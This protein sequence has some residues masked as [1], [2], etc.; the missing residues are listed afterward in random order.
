MLFVRRFR[1]V[2]AALAA[3]AM[4]VVWMTTLQIR[5]DEGS[6]GSEV[7]RVK[8]TQLFKAAD[9]IYF[10]SA[11]T[12]IEMTP[13]QVVALNDAIRSATD[14]GDGHMERAGAGYFIV[15]DDKGHEQDVVFKRDPSDADAI[16]VAPFGHRFTLPR[17][18]SLVVTLLDAVEGGASASTSS[19]KPPLSEPAKSD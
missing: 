1:W 18:R 5:H 19:A 12:R 2:L 7:D 15:V 17:M 16:I 3:V 4:I 6:K 14:Y 13:V 9:K 11:R 8:L 10:Y